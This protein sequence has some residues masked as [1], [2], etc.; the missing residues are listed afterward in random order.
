MYRIER[1]RV[2]AQQ[3][4]TREVEAPEQN[5]RSRICFDVAVE[6]LVLRFLVKYP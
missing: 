2:G 3:V 5:A 1:M 6:D 4:I